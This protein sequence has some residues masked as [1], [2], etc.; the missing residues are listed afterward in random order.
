MPL[1]LLKE[2]KKYLIRRQYS[3]A[4]LFLAFLNIVLFSAVY[5]VISL[6][7]SLLG[8]FFMVLLSASIAI[9]CFMGASR[10]W[11]ILASVFLLSLALILLSNVGYY[12][13]FQDFIFP[14]DEK[15]GAVDGPIM[16][17]L[18]D[19]IKVIPFLAYLLVA[20]Y[21]FVSC[22]IIFQSRIYS[23]RTFRAL[24]LVFLVLTTIGVSVFVYFDK[25]PKAN[26]W[27]RQE[28]VKD[29]GFCGIFYDRFFSH[30]LAAFRPEQGEPEYN[31]LPGKNVQYLNSFQKDVLSVKNLQ[32]EFLGDD[33]EYEGAPA[34]NPAG[35]EAGK[36]HIVI[37][38][39]ESVVEWAMH[40]QPN[41]MPFLTKLQQ[42]EIS[43]D[44]FIP[45]GC[46]TIDAEFTSLCGFYGP[47]N[48]PVSEAKNATE[49]QC[50]PE[51]LKNTMGYKT[52][53]LHSNV[54]EF[55]SRDK[56][57]PEWG[58]EEMYFTPYFHR[59]A[60]DQAVLQDVLQRIEDSTQPT[61]QY[62]VGFTSHGP[63]DQ[64]QIDA[65]EELKADMIPF[66]GE[67][68]EKT[69]SIVQTET[70]LKNYLGLVRGVDW[71]IESFFAGLDERG[72]ADNTIVVIYGDHK[73]YSIMSDEFDLF[74][75]SREVPFV[76]HVPDRFGVSAVDV[77]IASHLDIGPTIL[78]LLGKKNKQFVGQ[79]IF[80]EEH[81]DFVV[82]QCVGDVFALQ[83]EKLMRG[84]YRNKDYVFEKPDTPEAEFLTGLLTQVNTV[85][86]KKKY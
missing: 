27:N 45:N 48:K 20:T 66:E 36:P 81:E 71:A 23:K 84:L 9:F 13:I 17:L 83:D 54:P 77:K 30:A 79:S 50:L 10:I 61:F 26:W 16:D 32:N 4:I 56:L 82:H 12:S 53:L 41:P 68:S 42:E 59:R 76:M 74:Q 85:L 73:Y 11:R 19:Y 86:D 80:S 65:H 37:F 5:F 2:T 47:T 46:H 28:Y 58:F 62:V 70:T 34:H 55:W 21:I 57:A 25:N 49:F 3:Y 72:L 7:F 35:S 51:I 38:Q 18:V 52:A 22:Y 31:Q 6:P 63:H 15:F 44:H 40:E 14:L 67:L 1:D 78:D 29:Y 64:A 39:M 75:L 33:N 24:L 8:I 60:H 43:V 69:K